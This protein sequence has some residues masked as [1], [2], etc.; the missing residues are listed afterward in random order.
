MNN[1]KYARNEIINCTE[2]E[3]CT[4]AELKKQNKIEDNI[5]ICIGPK[6]GRYDEEV[7]TEKSK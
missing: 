1:C 2:H 5:L 7:K 4:N 3:I 6:C